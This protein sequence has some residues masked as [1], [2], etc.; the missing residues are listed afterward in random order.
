MARV[1]DCMPPP[2]ALVHAVHADQALTT[3]EQ[4]AACVHCFESNSDGHAAPPLAAGVVTVR[5]R[6][7]APVPHV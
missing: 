3:H 4:L 5:E 2:H 1:R 6:S 7:C